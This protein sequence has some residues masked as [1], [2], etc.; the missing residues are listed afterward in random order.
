MLNPLRDEISEFRRRVDAIYAADTSDRSA[1]REQVQHLTAL[2]QEVTIEAKNLTAA[3]KGEAQAQGA[4]GSSFWKPFSKN[5]F[6]CEISNT[7]CVPPLFRPSQAGHPRRGDQ[8]TRRK[9]H[10]SRLKSFA[11]SVDEKYCSSN[12]D[13]EQEAA[14]KEHLASIK[15]HVRELSGRN[16]AELY[17]I[18]S[19]DF[20]LM[21]IPIESAFSLAWRTE[22][23]LVADTYDSNDHSHNIYPHGDAADH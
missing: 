5:P 13:A 21:F 16:Y 12:T 9:T 18:T 2:N 20:V 3:L 14:L 1:L 22:P 6:F 4:W 11:H 7:Q 10:R 19:P 17:Q 8:S 23:N 15:K